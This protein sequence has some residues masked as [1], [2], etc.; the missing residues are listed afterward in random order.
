MQVLHIE[1]ER[2]QIRNLSPADLHPFHEYR[3]NPEVT[4]YQSFD[5]ITLQQADDFL[6][7]YEH[8][9]FGAVGEWVQYGIALRNTGQ[10]IGD[11]AIALQA[12]EPRIAE[13]GI[14]LSHRWQRQGFAKEAML[15]IM[16]FLF[17]EQQIHRIVETT[18]ADNKSS[19]NLMRS[20]GLRQEGYF[21]ENI[22]FKGKWSSEYQFALLKSEWDALQ[23]KP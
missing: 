22:F 17:D 15:G 10:L 4:R 19:V 12:D 9:R 8:A 7:Y 2:L 21:L 5:V 11:C 3:S 14:T 16:R 20:L 6:K 23:K 13:I 1:T 18:D